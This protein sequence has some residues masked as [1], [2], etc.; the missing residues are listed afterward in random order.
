M[1]ESGKN[2]TIKVKWIK[3]F[4]TI[5]ELKNI[6]NCTYNDLFLNRYNKNLEKDHSTNEK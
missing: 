3:N 2:K 4:S 6:Q 1:K 5:E